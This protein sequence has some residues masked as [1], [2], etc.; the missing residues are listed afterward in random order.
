MIIYEK[1]DLFSE[2]LEKIKSEYVEEVD[3]S[4]VMDCMLLM[5]FFNL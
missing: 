4:E 3:Q 5:V 2:V 1:I